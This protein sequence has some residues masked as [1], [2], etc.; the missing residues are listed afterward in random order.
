[1]NRR[2]N[3]IKCLPAVI[4]NRIVHKANISYVQQLGKHF[5]LCNQGGRVKIGNNLHTVDN[6]FLKVIKGELKIGNNVFFNNNVS[7]TAL[8]K[9]YIG[10]SVTIA[11]NVVIVDHDHSQDK[12]QFTSNP[13][14]IEDGVWIGANAVVLKDVHIGAKAIVAAGAVVTKDVP[15]GVVVAGVPAQIIKKI[16][17]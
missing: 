17:N 9:I 11:N 1:M 6:T 14:I 5:R 10:N 2:L 16:K 4:W 7:I 13:V 8:E 3:Q 15:G 12:G